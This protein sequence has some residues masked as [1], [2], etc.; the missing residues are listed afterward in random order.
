MHNSANWKRRRRG[1]HPNSVHL[2]LFPHFHRN[3]S[4]RHRLPSFS[5][6]FNSF[7]SSHTLLHN[8]SLTP[9]IRSGTRCRET[10]RD[11]TV[12]PE[13]EVE[14]KKKKKKN[15]CTVNTNT[16]THSNTFQSG[17]LSIAQQQSAEQ[18]HLSFSFYYL[19]WP[20]TNQPE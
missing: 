3:R 7:S 19:A 17:Q 15:H 18:S 16:H 9:L 13:Q 5:S 11:L 12:A 10:T 4:T 20:C 2:L 14:L 8:L 6:Y 1:K